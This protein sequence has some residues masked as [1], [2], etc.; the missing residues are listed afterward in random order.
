MTA[1]RAFRNGFTLVEIL[2][3]VVI[4]GIAAA[5]IIPKMSA[6]SDLHAAAAARVLI[7]DLTYAQNCAITTQKTHYV[8]FVV[9]TDTDTYSVLDAVSP[10]EHVM[11]HPV[12]MSGFA[13]KLGTGATGSLTVSRITDVAIEPTK[14]ATTI[15][16]DSLGSPKSYTTAGGL[17]DLVDPAT[18]D[19]ACNGYTLRIS[20]EPYTGEMSAI[21]VTP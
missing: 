16:F 19:V 9:G 8:K 7:S 11:T 18:I 13:Q 10:A 5:M 14:T 21:G 4:L 15:A 17:V 20:I 1:Q 2:V 3:V 12:T 6:A